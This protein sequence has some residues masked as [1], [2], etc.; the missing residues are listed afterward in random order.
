MG[1]VTKTEG[2]DVFVVTTT[3]LGEDFSGNSTLFPSFLG[4]LNLL[5][6]KI[7]SFTE[8]GVVTKM[9]GSPVVEE[10]ALVVD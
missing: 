7:F 2:S 3:S 6:L 1:V 5:C 4:K 9:A 8:E 10:S